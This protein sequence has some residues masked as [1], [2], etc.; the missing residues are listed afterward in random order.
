M[1]ALSDG[2]Y[3]V[4]NVQWQK[5]DRD[6]AFRSLHGF[7]TGKLIVSG[8]NTGL[9]ARFNDQFLSNRL[10]DLEE[11]RVPVNFQVE[12]LEHD[13][14]VHLAGSAPTVDRSGASYKLKV[15][16][17]LERTGGRAVA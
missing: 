13:E 1:S 11:D 4:T 9:T 12:V 6:E 15:E 8:S 16:G 10:S 14:A 3:L 7:T 2:E 5:A 17:T